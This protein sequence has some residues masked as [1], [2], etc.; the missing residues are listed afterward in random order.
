MAATSGTTGDH[1]HHQTRPRRQNKE[2]PKSHKQAAGRDT[3]AGDTASCQTWTSMTELRTTTQGQSNKQTKGKT[4]DVTASEDAEGRRATGRSTHQGNT[5]ERTHKAQQQPTATKTH[6]PDRRTTTER[7]DR[8]SQTR[9][10]RT[11]ATRHSRDT[12]PEIQTTKNR[13]S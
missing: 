11:T 3:T 10:H 1:T 7:Q 5:K 4:Q 12:K 6:R 8:R 2:S 13:K 9:K